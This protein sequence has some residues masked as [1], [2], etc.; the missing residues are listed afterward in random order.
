V[1]EQQILAVAVV[2]GILAGM[3]ELAV[4]AVAVLSLS[5]SIKVNYER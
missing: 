1:L 2:A 3:V 5:S 4:Q